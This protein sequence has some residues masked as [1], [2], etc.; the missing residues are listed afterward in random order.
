[1]MRKSKHTAVPLPSSRSKSQPKPNNPPSKAHLSQEY[2]G[3]TD[4]SD[5]EDYPR[6]KASAKPSKYTM[7][8]SIGIHRPNGVQNKTQVPAPKSKSTPSKPVSAEIE[9]SGSDGSESSSGDSDEQDQSKAN[10]TGKNLR[11]ESAQS[12]S[13]SG[14]SSDESEDESEE[15]S[16][17]EPARQPAPQ[18][19]VR[20]PKKHAIEIRQAQP[21]VPPKNFNAIA[22]TSKAKSVAMGIFDSLAGKELWHITT[23]DGVSLLDIPRD[24]IN[25]AMQ[26]EAVLRHNS[27]EYGISTTED[28]EGAIKEVLLPC[29]NG[30]KAV[31]SRITRT[32]QL[33]QVVRLPNLSSQQADQNTGS[34]AAA[35]ITQSTIRAPRP[36]I[37]GLKMRYTPSGFG[38]GE[39]GTLGSSDT[40][41]EAT[42][43]AGLGVPK[44]LPI[45][46]KPEKRRHDDRNGSEESPTKKHKKHKT[47]EEL[48]KRE[49]KKA[50]KREKEKM[51]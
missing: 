32:L 40:E 21:F 14:S 20:S 9:S 28:G 11:K 16:E 22:T 3:S 30:Y 18:E 49:E 31:P 23:R 8:V 19:H 27:I 10:G 42:A 17:E 1:M 29:A 5:L 6:D 35:S 26:G 47:P 25:K 39:P 2:V 24:E 12:V 44:G 37:K 15:E 33:R 50:K 46:K 45:L 38:T 4:E 36:Q 41:E 51:K 34:E 43:P 13:S 7:P 48:K